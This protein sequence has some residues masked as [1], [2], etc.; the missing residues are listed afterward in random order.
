[1]IIARCDAILDQ[2]D[3]QNLYNHLSIYT[4]GQ[5]C[6]HYLL[7]Y[8]LTFFHDL[9]VTD[10]DVSQIK[11][12]FYEKCSFISKSSYLFPGFPAIF[13][14]IIL[15]HLISEIAQTDKINDLGPNETGFV[16][17]YIKASPPIET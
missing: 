3:Q 17:F 9:F 1:M 7:L 10:D 11:S 12:C 15:V 2:S 6:M 5:L 4:N 14:S 16:R 8:I 13:I